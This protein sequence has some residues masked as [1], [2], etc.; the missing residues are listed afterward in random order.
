MNYV[1][2]LDVSIESRFKDTI[3]VKGFAVRRLAWILR[4]GKL[5]WSLEAD[6]F[7]R[8]KF[9]SSDIEFRELNRKITIRVRRVVN[10]RSKLRSFC[11]YRLNMGVA[12][13]KQK[14]RE[15]KQSSN[16]FDRLIESN[17]LFIL[18]LCAQIYHKYL[19][20]RQ[21]SFIFIEYFSILFNF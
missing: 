15:S 21:K 14:K 20:R 18:N 8:R 16:S 1:I 6:W 7:C 2:K 17:F 9:K 11:S 13:Y 5:W 3:I 10:L 19:H 4:Q 12:A